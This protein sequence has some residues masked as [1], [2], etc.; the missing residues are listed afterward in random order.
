[1]VRTSARSLRARSSGGNPDRGRRRAIR[2]GHDEVNAGSGKS[3]ASQRFSM[4][5]GIAPTPWRD[6][7]HGGETCAEYIPVRILRINTYAEIQRENTYQYVFYTM[8]RMPE[9]QRPHPPG[10]APRADW[11]SGAD[12]ERRRPAADWWARTPTLQV[13]RCA[14]IGRAGPDMERRR[15]AADWW[16]RTPTLQVP[17]RADWSSGAD[18]ERRR[19]AADWWARTPTLQAHA[20]RSVG[21][22][23]DRK[24]GSAS[25]SRR[26]DSI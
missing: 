9:R 18:M 10:A 5:A 6:S 25:P 12:M 8:V 21:Q 19:P 26:R 17:R 13:P 14:P 4:R 2:D 7:A 22:I 15:P 3:P 1:M 23:V 24:G 20:M 16:A 11:S